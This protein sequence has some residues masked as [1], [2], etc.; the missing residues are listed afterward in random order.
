MEKKSD[1]LLNDKLKFYIDAIARFCDKCGT[2]Y[3][4]SDLSIISDMQVTSII[5]FSC[6]NCKS[7]HIATF[8][9]PMGI[10]NRMPINTDL[11]V[12]EIKKFAKSKEISSDDVLDLYDSLKE[13][14]IKKI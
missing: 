7:H 12:T 4:T 3:T 5:H 2:P 8:I 10:S 9:K 1:S 11:T 14:K 6:S 13:Q